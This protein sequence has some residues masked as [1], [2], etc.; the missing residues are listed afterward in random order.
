MGLDAFTSTRPLFKCT[1]CTHY[2]RCIVSC[3]LYLFDHSLDS[4]KWQKEEV[5]WG[6]FVP[7]EIVQ[8]S[9]ALSVNRLINKTEWPG[10]N[11]TFWKVQGSHWETNNHEWKIWDYVPDGLL[12]WEAWLEY[13]KEKE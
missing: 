3:F 2:N 4:V 11:D 8:D 12:V 6:E 10:N 13:E 9:A 5:T 7:N 1:V